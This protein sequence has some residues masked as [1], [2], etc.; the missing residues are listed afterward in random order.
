MKRSILIFIVTTSIHKYFSYI[1]DDNKKQNKSKRV[2]TRFEGKKRRLKTVRV[3]LHTK[4]AFLSA[5]R[6]Y[7]VVVASRGVSK[8]K[9]SVLPLHRPFPPA[10]TRQVLKIRQD[11]K[12]RLTKSKTAM[13]QLIRNSAAALLSWDSEFIV[14][15]L[16]AQGIHTQG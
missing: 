16:G 4:T 11:G 15:S 9:S 3:E 12:K 14:H 1:H 5:I 2:A 13:M 10:V 7:I 6:I 8:P